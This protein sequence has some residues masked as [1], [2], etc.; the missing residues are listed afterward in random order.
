[1]E[2]EPKPQEK[3]NIIGKNLTSEKKRGISR[4]LEKL[5]AGVFEPIEG[6]LKKTPEQ[7]K[8]FEKIN[9]YINEEFE[10]L[11]IKK[12]AKILP[13]QFHF[14]PDEIFNKIFKEARSG[15]DSEKKASAFVR[16]TSNSVFVKPSSYT[17][18]KK[19]CVVL[20]HEAIHLASAEKYRLTDEGVVIR[21]RCGYHNI[22]DKDFK[23]QH[24][25]EFNEM[26]TTKLTDE[27][28]QKHLK[29]LAKEFNLSKK[30]KKIQYKTY[31]LTVLNL[32]ISEVAREND[33]KE[34]NVWRRFKKGLFT[35]EMMHLRDIER[36]FGKGS[37]RVIAAL[38]SGIKKEIDD[39]EAYNKIIDYLVTNNQEEK[40][41]IAKKALIEREWLAYKKQRKK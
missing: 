1:M 38:H 14:V 13:E 27:I 21:G 26:I 40:D 9:E 3:Y 39:K 7:L 32:I 29:E 10:E 22:R 33:E 20:L 25:C 30:E 36:I 35:G 18:K 31:E 16:P 17:D 34:E 11:D 12:K 37:L 41:K 5:Q 8:L 15:L 28:M 2:K 6:E 24:F 19:A 4:Q 23:Y